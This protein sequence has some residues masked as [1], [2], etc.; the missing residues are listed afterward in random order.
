[1]TVLCVAPY[2][3]LFDYVSAGGISCPVFWGGI[4]R[5]GHPASFREYPFF[6][7]VIPYL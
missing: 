6:L 3:R 4:S 5:N 2:F 1:M 7:T